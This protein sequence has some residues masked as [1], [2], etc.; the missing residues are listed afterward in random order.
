MIPTFLSLLFSIIFSGRIL[1]QTTPTHLIGQ[2]DKALREA[3]TLDGVLELKSEHFWTV[4]F[5]HMAGSLT[6]RVRRDADEQL[7]LAHVTNQL[8]GLVQRLTVQVR[9]HFLLLSSPYSFIIFNLS[10]YMSSLLSSVPYYFLYIIT[11]SEFVPR[12]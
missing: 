10:N 5:S 11:S 2:L 12:F 8:S 9:S 7:V 6:V 3:S 1:L 4:G